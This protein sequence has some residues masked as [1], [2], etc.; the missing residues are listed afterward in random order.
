MSSLGHRENG[1]LGDGALG[2]FDLARPLV[3]GREVRVQVP[4]VA[5][6]GR[7]L[8]A[9]RGDL[10]QGLAVVRHVGHDDQHV[11]VALVGQVFRRGQR[12][13][14]RDDPLDGRVV[15]KGKEHDDIGKNAACLEGIDEE[16]RHVVLDAHG[17]EHHDEWL[18]GGEDLAPGG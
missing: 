5:L 8:A 9:D 18:V 2:A 10:A 15:G 4:R 7:D 13:P 11:H 14:G 16:P 1:D 3:Q 12:A 17:G 6:A